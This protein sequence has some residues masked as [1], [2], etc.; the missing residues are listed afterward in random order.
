MFLLKKDSFS[1]SPDEKI[2]KPEQYADFM[3]AQEMIET[4]KKRAEQI[5]NDAKLAY[6][7]EKKRG[8]NKGMEEGNQKISE[9]MIEA[10][11]RSVKNFEAFENDMIGVVINALRKILGEMNEK[12]LVSRVVR[13]AL[14]T[15]R[16]QK[17]VNLTVNPD[18]VQVIKDQLTELLAQFPT[19]NFIEILSDPRISKGGCRLETEV[20]VV[21]ATIEIQVAA[22][23]RSLTR[24]V[25]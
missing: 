1:V 16:N 19:I 20:G 18:E 3:S 4:A 6:E 13:N 8:Y 23:K 9:F 12:E 22:I 17:K 7:E 11:E 2:L 24:T 14:E 10:V 25:K 15:V 5:V 21:D